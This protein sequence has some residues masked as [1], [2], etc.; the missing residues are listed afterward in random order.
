MSQ[1]LRRARVFAVL[2]RLGIP[3]IDTIPAFA[4]HP[5]PASLFYFHYKEEGNALVARETL[6]AFEQDGTN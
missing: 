2:A 4:A 3:V 5:D 6:R 1:E